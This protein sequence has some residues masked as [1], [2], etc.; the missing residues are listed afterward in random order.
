MYLQLFQ[1][2]YLNSS[3]Y[4]NNPWNGI[5]LKP[6][7]FKLIGIDSGLQRIINASILR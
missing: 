6:S 5:K 7:L 1:N 3:R 2:K 4:D